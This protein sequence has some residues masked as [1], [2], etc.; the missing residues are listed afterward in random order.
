MYV[1][2]LIVLALETLPVS[3]SY[4]L[5]AFLI[6]IVILTLLIGIAWLI[7]LTVMDIKNKGCCPKL[8]DSDDQNA[9]DDY[10]DSKS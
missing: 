7:Y 4:N 3:E 2:C 9:K 5:G 10:S 6:S 1:V 8:K